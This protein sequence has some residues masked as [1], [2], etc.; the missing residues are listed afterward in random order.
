MSSPTTSLDSPV[1]E[2]FP[3]LTGRQEPHFLSRQPGSSEH[4]EKAIELSVRIG[5]RP[6]PWQADSLDAILAKN[7]DGTWTH[8]DCCI[9]CPRQN[10]KSLILTLRIL[11][12][13]L[14]LGETIIFTAQRWTTAEDIYKR[15]YA[16]ISKRPSL[17]GRIANTTC[18]QG[19]G[20]IE[21]K[22]GNKVVFTTRS[23]DS[24]KGLTKLDLVIYD[25]AYNLTEGEM[26]A[27]GPTQLAALDPQTIY[28]SSPVDEDKDANGN[29]LA[30]IRE[31]GLAEEL[32]MYFAEFMAP[33]EMDREDEETWKYANPSYGVIQT[34]KKIRKLMRG[35]STARGRK[36]FDVDMLGRGDWPVEVVEFDSFSVISEE[37]WLSMVDKSPGL[38]GPIA[39]GLDRSIDHK[40]WAISAAQRTMDGRIHV[41]VGY[42]QSGSHTEIVDLLVDLIALWD[43]CVLVTDSRSSAAIIEPQLLEEEIELVKTSA[44]QMVTACGGFY[45]DTV[46]TP[47]MSHTNQPAL[48]DAVEGAVKRT[49]PK[50]DWAWD[51]QADAVIAPLV[52]ATLARWGLITYG[53]RQKSTP[54][55]SPAVEELVERNANDFDVLEDFDALEAAF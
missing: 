16:L 28:A 21:M 14:V 40:W 17:A 26:T 30:A 10:G 38:T 2:H 43:P 20:V 6:F 32:E 46:E 24:G 33:E 52:A 51:K 55:A 44:Q 23:Q 37:K 22:N 11:Y 4:G 3:K 45:D 19:R 9:L 41:E 25:E 39:L 35:M 31:R 15:T 1:H 54:V 8:P 42:F 5:S 29:V 12:G 18:S 53:S 47:I 34:A 49:L 36:S 27:L 7:P 13:L 50:G 48:T